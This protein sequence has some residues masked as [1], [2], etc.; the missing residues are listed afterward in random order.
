MS[1]SPPDPSPPFARVPTGVSG[2]DVVLRGGL[3]RGGLY[4]VEGAPGAGKTIL[5]NQLAFAHVAAG[6][7]ALYVTLLTEAHSRMFGHL[8]ALAF[9]DQAALGDALVYYSGAMA[10]EDGQLPGLLAMVHAALAER[11]ATLLVLD[12]LVTVAE[13]AAAEGAL[14]RFMLD[15]Q[16]LVEA[17]GATALLLVRPVPGR[18]DLAHTM[19]DG[20]VVLRDE[21]VDVEVL[22]L[23]EVRKFRGGGYL[24]GRHGYAIT[25]D[26]LAVY[27]R[28]EA[29]Y[30]DPVIPDL[31]APEPLLSVGVARLDAMLGG[32]LPA[33]AS[34]LV[35]GASGTGKT[36]LGLHFLDAG[37][38]AG[39]AGLYLGF[40]EPPAALL[41]TAD[42]LGLA[43]RDAHARGALTIAWQ[44]PVEEPLDALAE[45]LLADVAAQGARRLVLDGLELLSFLAQ[46]DARLVRFWAA[47]QAELRAR[48][49]TTLAT[50]R[51]PEFYGPASA[52]PVAGLDGMFDTLLFLRSVELRSQLYRL[53]SVLKARGR[54]ADRAIREFR[55]TARGMVV[56]ESF[57]G[58]EAILADAAGGEDD[59]AAD[60]PGR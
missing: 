46:R 39:E 36:P 57:D 2:L 20:V 59:D 41:A 16:A 30:A 15:L 4:L 9:F 34:A 13:T 47:L 21:A 40:D 25:D 35:A 29:R 12:S 6:G 27:P 51:L 43:L 45:R 22:R 8:R 5:G 37:A 10:L 53:V 48:G 19:V 28:T 11:R 26:G 60:H 44:L 50:L 58:A 56:A 42:G 18:A 33:G 3:L 14:R 32:G 31:R 7:R 17:H 49:V 24:R 38:R 52:V 55:F 1:A 54:A 23:L